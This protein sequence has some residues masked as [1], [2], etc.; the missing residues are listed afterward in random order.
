MVVP[1][2][3]EAANRGRNVFEVALLPFFGSQMYVNRLELGYFYRKAPFGNTT[4]LGWLW[5]SFRSP[6][7][8]RLPHGLS[9]F[10]VGSIFGIC[11]PFPTV[12]S[13]GLGTL[14]VEL[15]RNVP[16]IIAIL[17]GTAVVPANCCRLGT[18]FRRTRSQYSVFTLLNMITVLGTV[19]RR[20]RLRTGA[21]FNLCL[22]RAEERGA[23]AMRLLPRRRLIAM[24][25]CRMPIALSYRQ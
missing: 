5:V 25:C 22:A 20:P 4:Y 12:S 15:F 9:R 14:Y 11:V 10:L 6:P 21:R 18:W 3:P 8:F 7:A 16:L 2:G 19:Y 17:H 23:D 24:S 1:I 13:P